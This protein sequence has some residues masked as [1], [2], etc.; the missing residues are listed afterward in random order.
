MVYGELV[1]DAGWA[2][3][4]KFHI[5]A[6]AGEDAQESP[7]VGWNY[8]DESEIGIAVLRAKGRNQHKL[9]TEFLQVHRD[10]YR[11]Q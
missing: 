7:A 6:H 8:L 11:L 4:P 1:R 3:Y 10:L 2:W 9:C 5:M